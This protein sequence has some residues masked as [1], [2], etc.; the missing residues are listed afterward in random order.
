MKQSLQLSPLFVLVALA[1]LPF[2]LFSGCLGDTWW[3]NSIQWN[4]TGV[5]EALPAEG[6]KGNFELYATI[7][8]SALPFRYEG[9][10]NGWGVGGYSLVNVYWDG[11]LDQPLVPLA[12]FRLDGTLE[13]EATFE[14]TFN[15]S[16]V[17]NEFRVFAENVTTASSTQIDAWAQEF[18]ENWY[19]G[20]YVE[21]RNR[22]A[23]VDFHTHST[24]LQ[25]PLRLEALLGELRARGGVNASE[26]LG[27]AS[28]S[29]QGWG[30][31]FEFPVKGA[32]TT[33][34]DDSWGLL[35]DPQGRV[36]FGRRGEKDLSDAELAGLLRSTFAELGLPAPVPPLWNF[37]HQKGH[38][39]G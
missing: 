26:G 24:R 5:Y 9:L 11:T 23:Y 18:V 13:V 19:L 34:G 12:G 30:F 3:S 15:A 2:A 38:A 4:Q 20:G 39:D 6:R 17:R 8:A 25:G 16:V 1:Q 14:E 22:T 28:L 33:R 37:S 36:D 27:G 31:R 35:V 7:P 10:D 32:S 21:N 29:S